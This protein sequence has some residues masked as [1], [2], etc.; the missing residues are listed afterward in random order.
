MKKTGMLLLFFIFLFTCG[1]ICAETIALRAESDTYIDKKPPAP[2]SNFGQDWKMLM[3]GSTTTPAHGLLQFNLSGLPVGVRI[4]KARLTVLVHSN[5]HTNLFHVHP[6]TSVWGEDYATWNMAAEGVNWTTQGGDFDPAIFVE[7]GLPGSAPDWMVIDVTSLISDE[8]GNLNAGTAANGLLLK[9]DAGYNKVLTAEFAGYENA[10]TCHSCHGANDPS[11]DAGKSTN[12]AQCHSRGGISLSG[13]PTLIVDYEPMLFQF[14]QLSDTHIGKFPQA[15]VNLNTAVAQINGINPAFVLVTGDL[16]NDGTAEQ[17]G[18][19]KNAA[20]NL[21]MPHYCVPGDNDVIDGGTLDLYHQELGSDYYAF[22]YGGLKF[23][24]LN[25]TNT[26]SLDS[27][28]RQWLEDRL[29]EGEA[30]IIFAHEPL[31]DYYDNFT[32]LAGAE[33]LLSVLNAY[34]APLYM[35]GHTHQSG[36]YSKD[37]TDF[38]WCKNLDFADMGDPYN[39]YK[40]YADRILLYHVDMRN[41]SQSFAGTICLNGACSGDNSSTTTTSTSIPTTTTTAIASTTTT[42]STAASTTTSTSTSSSVLSTTSSMP[43]TTTTTSTKAKLCPAEIVFENEPA[44]LDLLRRFRDRVLGN[45]PEGR[46]WAA[47]Y[48]GHA[49]AIAGLLEKSPALR[50]QSR[51]AVKRLLPYIGLLVNDKAVDHRAM[52]RHARTL[53]DLYREKIGADSGLLYSMLR[54]ASKVSMSIK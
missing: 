53:I 22:D 32:A 46:R 24:G 37:G 52:R 19:F 2:D 13:E 41:G 6:M 15:L 25:N 12:C 34:Q 4:I 23:I 10:L 31:L 3:S 38:V 28:Q 5:Q 42:S 40:V 45:T 43:A 47:F 18:D 50:L 35:N 20:D 39:L 17:Y 49:D 26:L 27:A 51:S 7:A 1:N 44:T 36:Q 16:T 8:Q 11:L 54:T 33:Q 9:A 48:Y 29:K 30:G 21:T 14:V